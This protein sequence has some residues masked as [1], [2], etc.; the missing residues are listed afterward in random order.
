MEIIL[1]MYIP[2]TAV[3]R[4][5]A[6]WRRALAT[7]P[8]VKRMTYFTDKRREHCIR[9][10]AGI[11]LG[12]LE[13]EHRKLETC[14]SDMLDGICELVPYKGYFQLEA[15]LAKP[16]TPWTGP[17]Y[18]TDEEGHVVVNTDSRLLDRPRY[19]D[20]FEKGVKQN[21]GDEGDADDE[22]YEDDETDEDVEDNNED[23]GDEGN[24]C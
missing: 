10:D 21:M 16:H 24:G 14:D 6:F 22:D 5:E 3:R 2:W 7:Q 18:T 8:P 15:L 4:P 9:N 1:E 20:D 12:D 17:R 11:T 19:D 23:E 13:T